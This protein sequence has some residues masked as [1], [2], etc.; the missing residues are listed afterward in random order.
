MANWVNSSVFYHIYP[1]GFCGAPMLNAG[2]APVNRLKKI[3]EWIP[4]IKEGNFN[5]IYLGPVFESAVHGYDTTDYRVID[6][7][8]GT[9]DDFK[10]LC[11]ELHDNGIRVVLDGVFNHVGRDFFAFKDLQENEYNSRYKNWFYVDFGGTSPYNDPFS[12]QGWQGHYNL[13]KLNI[14]NPEVA[15]YILGSVGMWMDEFGIDGLRLDAADCVDIEFFKKLK[16]FTKSKNPDFWLMGEIIHGDY[17]RWANPD[18]LDS[19]TNYEC[20]KGIYSS[21]NDKNY[22]EIAHSLNRQFGRGGIYQN[23]TL[24]SFVD[25]HDVNRLASF[26]K[27]QE[28]LKNCYTILYTMP[29]V[30]SVYYGS[31]WGIKGER[32]SASDTVLRP[33]LE[34]DNIPD[35]DMSLFEH[36]KSLGK[37]H[38]ELVALQVG[39]FENV[40]IRN[41]Q[42]VYKRTC[43]AGT[44]YVALNL[45]DH[46][47]EV[48]FNMRGAC[49]IDKLD[50]DRQYI[51]QNGYISI[52]MPPF[53]S[54]ILEEGNAA[55]VEVQV[56][57]Q[58]ILVGRMY[59]HFKGNTYIV[60][61]IGKDSETMQDVVVY[62]EPA[63]EKKVWVRPL[64]MFSGDVVVDGVKKKRFT[65][66]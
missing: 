40:V 25:N 59:K 30:P 39:E 57:Q 21:H 58:G 18:V 52:N 31:E 6:R 63:G 65:L 20:Q 9:N 51:P 28:H 2:G 45:A 47:A 48:G 35:A 22:F 62:Q 8:L 43:S 38:S 46:D 10:A 14:S 27:R 41:E 23:L 49:L 61:A 17:N 32:T 3:S 15:D 26:L 66:Q 50:N 54:M 53:S 36:I 16:H 55:K 7:R 24:Y 37:I 34:L 60:L 1:L 56:E 44:V 13:V 5:A 64:D 11:R 19:V 12:Y 42:L 4:H 33:S 29:G